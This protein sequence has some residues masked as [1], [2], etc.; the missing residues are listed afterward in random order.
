MALGG[1]LGERA[2]LLFISRV[3]FICMRGDEPARHDCWLLLL[4]LRATLRQ[5]VCSTVVS[6]LV[7]VL[8]YANLAMLVLA[9]VDW[10]G[11]CAV[12]SVKSS[13]PTCSNESMMVPPPLCHTGRREVD[14]CRG[15]KRAQIGKRLRARWDGLSSD[16]AAVSAERIEVHDN[17][18]IDVEMI[19]AVGLVLYS[20]ESCTTLY[21]PAQS[22]GAHL[23]TAAGPGQVGLHAG[24]L[25]TETLQ[26]Q[27]P[28]TNP[29]SCTDNPPVSHST[30][31]ISFTTTTLEHH[32][33][34]L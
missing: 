4:L 10:G 26:P 8:L 1:G 3:E 28:G 29:G 16:E 31:L 22:S 32:Q 23:P 27:S 21:C 18:E 11:S 12:K 30:N 14:T 20:R 33:G 2:M 13:R 9:P 7:L 17:D 24:C 15:L 34:R 19:E 25:V 6:S 5:A